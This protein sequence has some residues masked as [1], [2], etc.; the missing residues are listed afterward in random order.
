ME[1]DDVLSRV[2]LWPRHP[3][4]AGRNGHGQKWQ[5]KRA[6]SET[7]WGRSVRRLKEARDRGPGVG[8]AD[9]DDPTAGV[10]G[11]GGHRQYC[12]RVGPERRH[13]VRAFT[14][15]MTS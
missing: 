5:P 14:T 4:D 1:L 15:A 2:G 3:G 11:R 12:L 9:A 8:T 7:A 13:H 6:L 10:S